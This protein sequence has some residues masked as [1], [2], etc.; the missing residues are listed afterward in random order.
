MW[1]PLE[2][3]ALLLVFPDRGCHKRE[4]VRRP[5]A[6]LL[7]GG[8]S[9]PHPFAVAED[10]A[11]ATSAV[12]CPRPFRACST[13]LPR[14]WAGMG[15]VVGSIPTGGEATANRYTRPVWLPRTLRRQRVNY[16]ARASSGLVQHGCQELGLVW[17]LWWVRL[18]RPE[19]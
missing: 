17:A 3:T 11:K 18:P 8:S 1:Q 9:P 14:A 16:A 10:L 19:L 6:V 12:C 15:L 5:L 7:L 13:W 4:R 2:M